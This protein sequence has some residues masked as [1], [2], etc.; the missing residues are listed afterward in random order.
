MEPPHIHGYRSFAY[1]AIF[2]TL[3]RQTLMLYA[4]QMTADGLVSERFRGSGCGN[5]YSVL[6][7]DVANN[8]PRGDDH[9]IFIMDAYMNFIHEPEAEGQS[10]LE[11]IWPKVRLAVMWHIEHATKYGLTED[12]VHT[13]DEHGLIGDV[14]SYY[15]FL[16]ISSLSA[17]ILLGRKTPAANATFLD[18]VL[19][20]RDRGLE[21][22]D[23]LLWAGICYLPFWCENGRTLPDA[24]QSE[25]LY[26]ALWDQ[27][28]NLNSMLPVANL[29]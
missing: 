15:S 22:L 13:F 9:A 3:E 7:L 8:E 24:L 27:L 12:R 28:L 6:N 21:A 19:K 18:D 10:F 4:D 23:K 20:A 1:Q 14:N 25:S 2:S 16:Y 5:A 17:A 26:G 29:V 11:L